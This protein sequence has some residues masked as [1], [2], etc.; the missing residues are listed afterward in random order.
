LM[1]SPVDSMIEQFV[2]AGASMI[3]FHPEASGHV[4]RSLQLIIDGGC[5]AGLVLNPCH[6]VA[7]SRPC[8]A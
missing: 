2:Q 5:Q 3:S 4:D 1:V 6:T 8:T 7:C